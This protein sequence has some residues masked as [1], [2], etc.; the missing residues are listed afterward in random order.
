M[1]LPSGGLRKEILSRITKELGLQTSV[2][3]LP[4]DIVNTIQPVLVS[5]S[6]YLIETASVNADNATTNTFFTTSTTK[7]T[8]LVSAHL[9]VSKDASSDST[10][11]SIRCTPFLESALKRILRI[12]YNPSQ[13]VDNLSKDVYFSKPLKLARGSIVSV[14]NGSATATISASGIVFYYVED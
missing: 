1:A 9:S 12:N 14:T 3:K 7:D 5:N 13:A 2:D 4:M 6:E 8:Y 10:T 11:S